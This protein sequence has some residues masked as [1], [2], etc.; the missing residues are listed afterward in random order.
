MDTAQPAKGTP[1]Q[2]GDATIWTHT[3]DDRPGACYADVAVDDRRALTFIASA[4][5]DS[6]GNGP[7]GDLCATALKL[8]T[9]ALPHL[10]E[11]NLRANSQRAHMNSR[12]AIHDPCAILGTLGQGHHP[13]LQAPESNL[14]IAAMAAASPLDTVKAE[15]PRKAREFGLCLDRSYPR[16]IRSDEV[17]HL[18]AESVSEQR[19]ADLPKR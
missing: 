2:V 4:N 18:N 15:F 8:A 11:R 6:M 16:S 17:H 12:L 1:H 19:W 5:G 13:A 9:A 14:P 7:K 10:S 3:Y